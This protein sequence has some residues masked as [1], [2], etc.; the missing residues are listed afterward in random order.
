MYNVSELA[1]NN[2]FNAPAYQLNSDWYYWRGRT[3]SVVPA[4][5]EPRP[6]RNAGQPEYM[7]L[8]IA[9]NDWPE[10]L[11]NFS[12]FPLLLENPP[13][14]FSP[15]F[16]TFVRDYYH[17]ACAIC[18]QI[19][20]G[21]P[22]ISLAKNP[23]FGEVYERIIQ[24]LKGLSK[25]PSVTSNE[26]RRSRKEQRAY[27]ALCKTSRLWQQRPP[28]QRAIYSYNPHDWESQFAAVNGNNIVKYGLKK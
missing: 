16:Y 4:S 25:K 12:L 11:D 6:I 8:S 24:Q 17:S 20:D 26:K 3:A 2:N 21:Q 10:K 9:Y 5:D 28:E 1:R 18:L 15:D 22:H 23:D 27:T 19:T 7:P 13:Y 14:R